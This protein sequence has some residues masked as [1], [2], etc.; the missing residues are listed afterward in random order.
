MMGWFSVF[1]SQF[2]EFFFWMNRDEKKTMTCCQSWDGG[3]CKL[4]KCDG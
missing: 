4:I 2:F 3:F 1:S